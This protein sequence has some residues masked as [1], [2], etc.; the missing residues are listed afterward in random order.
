MLH[1]IGFLITGLVAGLLARALV[2]GR[3]ELSLGKTTLLGAA[4]ALIA[5]FLGR[6]AGWYG[7]DDGA[8]FIA[9]TVGAIIVL[10][11]Y[12]AIAK[13]RHP[14]ITG[15]HRNDIRDAA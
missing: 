3:Q 1:L 11:A 14:G 15:S 6:A 4:G 13:S 10:M 2:P 5:G 8:G 12:I 9:A 7:P